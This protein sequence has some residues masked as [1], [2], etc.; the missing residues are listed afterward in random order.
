MR[1]T[2]CFNEK[3][4]GR[5]QKRPHRTAVGWLHRQGMVKGTIASGCEGPVRLYLTDAGV[6]CTEEF[7]SDT[8]RYLAAQRPAAAG[9]SGSNTVTIHGPASGVVV[10]SHGVTQR[11]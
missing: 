5:V 1:S 10:G 6:A 7:G 11:R 8:A 2:R 3:L 4:E 9:P